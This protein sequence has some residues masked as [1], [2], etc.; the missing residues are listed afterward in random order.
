MHHRCRPHV[1]VLSLWTF[2]CSE[3]CAVQNKEDDYGVRL[4]AA[5]TAAK[6]SSPDP[7]EST[8]DMCEHGAQLLTVEPSIKLPQLDE[9]P[10]FIRHFYLDCIDGAMSNLDPEGATKCRRFIIIGNPGSECPAG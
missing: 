2:D 5:L 6:F 1:S 3:M 4:L 8:V 10:L 7:E 9:A